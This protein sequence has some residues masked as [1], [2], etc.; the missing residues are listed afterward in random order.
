MHL[1]SGESAYIYGV[2]DPDGQSL[3]VQEGQAKGWVL[4][5][6]AIG[7]NPQDTSGTNN[8]QTLAK[9]GFGIIARLNNAYGPAG[10]I[11]YQINYNNFARRVANFVR[12]SPGCHIWQIGNEMNFKQEQPRTHGLEV[13]TPRLYA[14][15]FSKVRNTIHQLPG[16]EHDQ[17]II[18]AIA[19]WNG[20][21]PYDADPQGKYPAN[22]IGT[23]GDYIRYL[24]DILLALGPQGCD[25]ISVHAYTHGYDP[26]LVFSDAKMG[27]PFQKYYYN[28]RT[29]R[30]QIHAIPAEFYHLPVYMT[31][32]DGNI[33]PN[34]NPHAMWPDKNSG[35]IQNMYKEVNDW[36]Q[37]TNQQIRCAILYRWNNSA[38]NG[39]DWGIQDK[40][41]VQQDLL[42]ALTHNYQW[43]PAKVPEGKTINHPTAKPGNALLPVPYVSQFGGG[44]T[45]CPD[46]SGAASG[47]MLVEAYTG[48]TITAAQFYQRAGQADGR[49]LGIDHIQKVLTEEGIGTTFNKGMTLPQ[50]FQALA[51]HKPPLV[52]FNYGI[53]RKY[54]QTENQS[55]SGSHFG[56]IVGIDTFHVYL[57]D[58]FWAKKEGSA[59]AIPHQAWL[60]MWHVTQPSGNQPYAALVPTVGIKIPADTPLYKVKVLANDLHIRNAPHVSLSTGTQKYLHT[61]NIAT[62][63]AEDQNDGNLWGAIESDKQR[64]IALT[65]QGKELAKRI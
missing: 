61:G 9:G 26:N 31:E 4:I 57:N 55:F 48:S 42:N 10:T 7:H 63:W 5:T 58:P 56:V 22:K 2:H 43:N 44:A 60:D 1:P 21:T 29:Y 36:N 33:V 16:H 8:Y 24:T 6:E 40:K 18:G 19:P 39:D 59:L 37:G 53:L 20:D 14:T 32:T 17:V 35:W 51:D 50:L 41:N 49:Q 54:I 46:D 11:P 13:I 62:I 38:N 30:D 27:P 65:Y 3:L 45:N 28:F 12:S 25:G 52:I 64:W 15:C 47:A 23:V 34:S